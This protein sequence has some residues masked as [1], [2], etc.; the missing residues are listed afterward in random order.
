MNHRIHD[1]IFIR[2]DLVSFAPAVYM[3]GFEVA[4]SH[5]DRVNDVRSA[6]RRYQ[7]ALVDV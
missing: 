4:W 5:R 1:L 7:Y 3:K 6:R 2:I